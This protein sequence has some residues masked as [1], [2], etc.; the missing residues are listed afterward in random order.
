MREL[1][2]SVEDHETRLSTLEENK[3]ELYKIVTALPETGEANKFFLVPKTSDDTGDVYDE[4]IWVNKGTEEEPNW[5]WEFIGTKK[6]EIE[7]SEYVKFTDYA[8]ASK[9]GVVK[10]YYNQWASGIEFLSD[11]S[12]KVKKADNTDIVAK[13]SETTPIVPKNQDYAFKMS[14]T[15]NKETWTD[16]EKAKACETIGATRLWRHSCQFQTDEGLNVYYISF[17]GNF[18]TQVSTLS[19][20]VTLLKNNN[21]RILELRYADSIV[22]NWS[23]TTDNTIKLSVVVGTNIQEKSLSVNTIVDT[24]TEF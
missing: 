22:L 24:V 4:W 7:L 9:A 11:G 10:N 8:T 3:I 16:E 23:I 19:D 12:I 18:S 1:S 20:L 13:I 2:A 21:S 5:D 6:F 17:L 14:A 15:D